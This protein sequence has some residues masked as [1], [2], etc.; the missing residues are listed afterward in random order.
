MSAKFFQDNNDK[1]LLFERSEFS[2]F[3]LNLHLT[4]PQYQPLA[5]LPTAWLAA[6][7]EYRNRLRRLTFTLC[8]QSAF[9]AMTKSDC[10]RSAQS[11]GLTRSET[12][13]SRAIKIVGRTKV[14]KN[15]SLIYEN[16]FT[17]RRLHFITTKLLQSP[18]KNLL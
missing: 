8:R 3:E 13:L 11:G 12:R 5:F 16:D 14:R 6:L 9:C 15:K 7:N 1:R 4:K 2:R 17:I 18:F 10:E